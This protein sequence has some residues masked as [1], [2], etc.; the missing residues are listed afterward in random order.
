MLNNDEM[1]SE[2][3]EYFQNMENNMDYKDI[4]RVCCQFCRNSLK[5]PKP[6][7]LLSLS[8]SIFHFFIRL[9]SSQLSVAH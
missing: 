4:Y 2:F 9:L 1:L 5:S 3:R 8:I 6:D 7:K